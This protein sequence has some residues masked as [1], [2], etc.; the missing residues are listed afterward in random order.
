MTNIGVRSLDDVH[1]A[2]VGFLDD[3]EVVDGIRFTKP[4]LVK[5][6]DYSEKIVKFICR[7][8]EVL[9]RNMI[10]FRKTW[11]FMIRHK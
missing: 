4:V 9:E 1:D 8:G 5:E 6:F 7:T 3:N 10:D 11:W 2:D